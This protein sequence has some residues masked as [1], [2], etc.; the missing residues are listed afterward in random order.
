MEGMFPIK[1]VIVELCKQFVL[2]VN[3]TSLKIPLFSAPMYTAHLLYN[4]QHDI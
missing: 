4:K 3:S 1:I 2:N